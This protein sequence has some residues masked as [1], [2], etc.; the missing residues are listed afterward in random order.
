[1]LR[2]I[3]P[4]F[5]RWRINLD[6]MAYLFDRLCKPEVLP[7]RDF[8]SFRKRIFQSI[9]DEIKRITSQRQYFSGFGKLSK[10]ES[11]MGSVLEFGIGRAIGNTT[12][13]GLIDALRR[14]IRRSILAFEPRLL[15]PKVSFIA[16]STSASHA[17]FS[18]SGYVDLKSEFV[19][20]SSR[21]SAS[22]EL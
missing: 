13:V 7:D 18:V 5:K 19:P 1:M 6:I 20:Y 16:S 22:G 12:S 4:I 2:G 14:D 9:T 17:Q 8:E 11:E 21:F 15:K 3:D 10:L